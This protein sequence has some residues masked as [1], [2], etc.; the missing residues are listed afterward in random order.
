MP[1]ARFVRDWDQTQLVLAA[2]ASIG[3][4]WQMP[5]GQAAYLDKTVAKSTGDRTEF[6]TSGFATVTKTNGIYLIDG[7]PVY[8]DHSA[9]SATFRQVS[10]RDFYIGTAHGDAES[11][12]LTCVV[13]LNAQGSYLIDLARDAFLTTIVGTQALGGLALLRRGGA[14]NFVL[15]STSEAQKL[16]ALSV[17][18]FAKGANWIVEGAFRVVSDG[19]GT[20]VDVNL[21]I[22][23]GTNATDADSITESCFVHLDANNT[24]IN[25]E[26]DDGTTEVAATDTTS[27]YTEGSALANRVEFWMDGRNPADVQ[28][29]ING[30]LQLGSTVFNIDAA[31]GPLFLLAHV[32]KSSAADTYEL[33]LDWLRVRIAEQ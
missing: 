27:D 23:N 18:G 17:N 33:A 26:S 15:S 12:D 1:D 22:A 16:D 10:D 2:G 11:G 5:N 28:I 21:G 4:V 13:N 24:N 19:A 32:E 30:V 14:H 9:N 29:Y 3:E 8:W 6:R 7:G 31:V 20:V 25:L